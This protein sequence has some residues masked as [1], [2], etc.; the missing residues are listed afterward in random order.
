MSSHLQLYVLT[1]SL[2][3]VQKMVM[4]YPHSLCG[5]SVLTIQQLGLDM[6]V[7]AHVVQQT[8]AVKLFSM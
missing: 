8:Q 4:L 6:Q 5:Y 3:I 2:G 7:G 1:L